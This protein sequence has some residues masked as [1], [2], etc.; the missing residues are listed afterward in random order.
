MR[1]KFVKDYGARRVGE[2][3]DVEPVYAAELL[4]EGAVVPESG[5]PAPATPEPAP[6]DRAL[7]APP[8]GRR[9]RRSKRV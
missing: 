8:R 5:E 4:A 3:I 2:V 9:K 6:Q 1:Y 7:D